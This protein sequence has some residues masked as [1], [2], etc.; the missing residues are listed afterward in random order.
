M[1]SLCHGKGIVSPSSNTGFLHHQ[2]RKKPA[3]LVISLWSWTTSD[4]GGPTNQLIFFEWWPFWD[5]ENVTLSLTGEWWPPTIGDIICKILWVAGG[6]E[7]LRGYFNG[8]L[9][10]I[11]LAPLGGSRASTKRHCSMVSLLKGWS[12]TPANSLV[13]LVSVYPCYKPSL[14]FRISK[15]QSSL[16]FGETNAYKHML[17][18][19]C[20]PKIFGW[21]LG[22]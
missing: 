15:A 6:V 17:N 11:H 20:Q 13:R 3:V 19:C 1:K 16:G 7:T 5:G 4:L 12:S 22:A 10:P 21:I 18:F 14:R 2:Y 8:T 9:G